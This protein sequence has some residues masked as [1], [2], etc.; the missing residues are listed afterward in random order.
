LLS[1]LQKRFEHFLGRGGASVTIP[2]M[3]GALKPN[4]LLD[5]ARSIASVSSPD[6]LIIADGDAFFT[7]A[8]KLMKVV[9]GQWD[10]PIVA[11]AFNSRILAIAASPAGAL[12]IAL[13]GAGVRVM[14]GKHDGK[15]IASS[16]HGPLDCLV[17]LAYASEDVLVACNGSSR[18]RAA[19]WQR[20]LL[21]SESSGSVLTL[22]LSDGS[23]TLV[24]DRLAFPYGI[25]LRDGGAEAVIAESWKNR[26]LSISLRAKNAPKVLLDGLTGYPSRLSP[27]IGGGAWLAVFAP[28]S[29]LIE[30]VLREKTYRRAM[31]AEVNPE[32]W[33][34]PALYSGRS[35]SE[36]MQGGA[37]KQMGILKPW[38]PT[39]SYGLV[40]ELG[41]DL[42]PIRSMH[43]RAGGKR[44]GITSCQQFGGELLMTSR[45]GDEI[46]A[47]RV[48]AGDEPRNSGS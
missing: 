3:D 44:H 20:D 28:R 33:I 6:N 36:P 43:S 38:A 40:V 8:N 19:D 16:A 14:G 12:A 31:M 29:Q 10:A 42:E 39:R 24:A 13:D 2:P 22:D 5:A 27:R 7:T 34:A 23:S 47:I 18:N 48:G 41:L 21:E 37:L 4:N 9:S 26:L 32:F 30:F 11:A 35:F 25:L 15:S 45:G 46:I 17:A 1:G